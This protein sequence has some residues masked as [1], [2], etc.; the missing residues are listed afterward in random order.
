M[1][2]LNDIILQQN[3]V[4]DKNTLHSYCDYFYQNE[5]DKYRDKEITIAEIGVDQCGSL[6]LWAEYFKNPKVYGLDLQ[7]RGDCEKNTAKYKNITLVLGDAYSYDALKV[8]PQCDI[9]ID[10][11]S[12]TL[13]HQLFVVKNYSMKV[14]P[15]GMLIIEDIADYNYLDK[16]QAAT[17]FHLQKHVQFVDFRAIKNRSDDI[18]FVIRVPS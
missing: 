18:M 7:L 16:L 11:G 14:K 3:L 4:T 2:T 12:H 10:D 5:F 6:I 17:P 13:E 8:L 1:T 15:G 9:I